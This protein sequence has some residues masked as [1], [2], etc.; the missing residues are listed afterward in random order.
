M[1]GLDIWCATEDG[2]FPD[3]CCADHA[4]HMMREKVQAGKVGI[5]AGEGFFS[6]PP[7]LREKAEKAF[8]HRLI[9]QGNAAERFESCD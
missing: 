2:L 8:F 5:K 4:C 7:E 6:Y 1:G 9:V 3:L